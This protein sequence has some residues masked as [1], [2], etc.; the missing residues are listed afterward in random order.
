MKGGT[1]MPFEIFHVRDS[2]K[3]IEE[4]G[5]Q[6]DLQATLENVDI[7]LRGSLYRRELLRGRL[8]ASG[9]SNAMIAITD[10]LVSLGKR[11]F[12]LL[13]LSGHMKQHVPC[14]FHCKL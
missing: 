8:K 6:K 9:Y 7:S 14:F 11:V 13:H 3:I 4:K 2:D 10:R 1:A 5:L 12:A